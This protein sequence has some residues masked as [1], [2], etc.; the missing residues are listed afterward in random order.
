M[1]LWAGRQPPAIARRDQIVGQRDHTKTSPVAQLS[2]DRGSR[3]DSHSS[4]RARRRLAIHE[5]EY[6]PGRCGEGRF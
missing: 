1:A 2:I 6:P 4:G 5:R 3:L